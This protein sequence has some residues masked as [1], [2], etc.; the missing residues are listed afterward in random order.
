MRPS[1][2]KARFTSVS[3]ATV[4]VIETLSPPARGAT[5]TTRTGLISGAGGGALS[6]QAPSSSRTPRQAGTRSMV[7]HAACSEAVRGRMAF[8]VAATAA[9]PKR[10]ANKMILLQPRKHPTLAARAGDHLL[11]AIHQVWVEWVRA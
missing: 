1:M 2:R 10:P 11:D 3:A 4:P 9:Y 8:S 7:R 5:V 6:S